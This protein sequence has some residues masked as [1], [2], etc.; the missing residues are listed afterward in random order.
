V[1]T[2]IRRLD[3]DNLSE[4]CQ[5]VDAEPAADILILVQRSAIVRIS[6]AR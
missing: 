4:L 6:S 2:I 5:L 3:A 1:F